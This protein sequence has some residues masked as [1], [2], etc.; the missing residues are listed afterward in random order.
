MLKHCNDEPEATLKGAP[1]HVLKKLRVNVPQVPS[2]ANRPDLS[3]AEACAAA[4]QLQ[5]KFS[6][7][8][9]TIAP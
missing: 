8:F 5:R 9:E 4:R 2:H 7:Y 1:V 6:E 3:A